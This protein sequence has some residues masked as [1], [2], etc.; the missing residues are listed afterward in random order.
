MDTQK[1]MG[2]PPKRP[3][4]RK[5]TVN[6]RLDPKIIEMLR[7]YGAVKTIEAAI[8]YYLDAINA[9]LIDPPA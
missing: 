8:P 5:V 9:G 2:R 6:Y 3:E 7:Q 4:E 1:K